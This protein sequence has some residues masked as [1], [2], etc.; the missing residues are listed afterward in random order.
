MKEHPVLFNAPM[1]RALLD[2]TKTQTR[3]PVKGVP[4]SVVRFEVA[5]LSK[6]EFGK[7][8][9]IW[10]GWTADNNNIDF[11]AP[12]PFGV[13]GD[14]LWVRETWAPFHIGSKHSLASPVEDL[15]DADGA[16]FA[17]DRRVW[18]CTGGNGAHAPADDGG[19][20]YAPHRWR[21]S[22]HMPRWASRI[23]LEVTDVRVQRVQDI[24]E[25]DAKAEG[26]TT[27]DMPEEWMAVR[28]RAMGY[29]ESIAFDRQPSSVVI[30]E[31]G[32]REVTRHPARTLTSTRSGFS[33][34]WDSVYD[35]WN[36]NPWVWAV[37]FRRVAS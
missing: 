33:R 31:L 25:E 12:C 13:V 9:P 24:S 26:V 36:A 20:N 11:H 1:I 4:P 6:T 29:E 35:S 27:M 32:L 37:S 10:L 23:T 28:R 22:I 7:K 19:W 15:D 21:P 5:S 17:A 18:S 8:A 3:R 2:G 14:R 34:L 16:R 30:D